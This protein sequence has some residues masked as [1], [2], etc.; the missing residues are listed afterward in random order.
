MSITEVERFVSDVRTT[1]KL[2]S[3]MKGKVQ[4]SEL[5]E[6]AN[7]AGYRITEEDVRS[8]AKHAEN[9]GELTEKQLE[10]VAGGWWADIILSMVGWGTGDRPK[11]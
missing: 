1:A 10:T 3:A 8:Y 4:V 9:R 11:V 7:N 6:V 5:V 2:Q